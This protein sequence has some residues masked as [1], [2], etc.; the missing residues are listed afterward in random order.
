MNEKTLTT[1]GGKELKVVTK[2]NAGERNTLRLIFRKIVSTEITTDP[3]KAPGIVPKEINFDQVDNGEKMVI[4]LGVK[5]YGDLT[6]GI[7]EA[8]LKEDIEEF[9]FVLKSLEDQLAVASKSF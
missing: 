6:S 5:K 2:F 9:D 1:P 4:V 7:Y 8:L 3:T